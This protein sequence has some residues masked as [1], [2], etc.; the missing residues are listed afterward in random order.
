MRRTM[1]LLA[2]L[3]LIGGLAATRSADAQNGCGDITFTGSIATQFPEAKNACLGIETRN[4][5]QFAHFKGEIVSVSGQQVRAK[6]KLPDGGYS[7]TYAFTPKQS[8]RI[9]INGATYRHSDLSPGQQL[10]VYVPP[11]RWEFAVP[12]SDTETF[13]A[14]PTVDV[15]RVTTVTAAATAAALP[16]TASSVPLVGALAVILLALGAGLALVRRRIA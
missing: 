11:S 6:F 14:A 16:E 2:S 13:A 5:E 15:F 4:G 9:N 3:T 7:K 8:S 1:G 12:A 10:D